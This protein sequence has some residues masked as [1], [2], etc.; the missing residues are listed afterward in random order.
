[1][2]SLQSSDRIVFNAP[3]D[4]I[5]RES[6]MIDGLVQDFGRDRKNDVVPLSEVDADTLRRVIEY[7]EYHAAQDAAKKKDG[8]DEKAIA[9]KA[10]EWNRSFFDVDLDILSSLVNAANYLDMQRLLDDGC[11]KIANMIKGKSV[12][13]IR[14]ILGIESD[15]T[16]EEEDNIK[17]EFDWMF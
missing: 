12:G 3:S 10:L 15:M 2:L 8:A 7:C 1:M 11:M 16:K 17:K 14:A 5:L 4:V 9:E 6:K 13:E